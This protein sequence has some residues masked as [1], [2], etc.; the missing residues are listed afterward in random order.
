MQ[1]KLDGTG[2]PEVLET[3]FTK[4]EIDS[5]STV[6]LIVRCMKKTNL[7]IQRNQY[8]NIKSGKELIDYFL[9]IQES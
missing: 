6:D 8:Q 9:K 3:P 2:T 7:K 1:E 4:L 5:L